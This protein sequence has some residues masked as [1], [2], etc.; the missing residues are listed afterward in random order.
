[1]YC[2]DSG[3]I[4]TR[5]SAFKL[6]KTVTQDTY[7]VSILCLCL[8]WWLLIDGTRHTVCLCFMHIRIQSIVKPTL[9]Y[10]TK[11]QRYQLDLADAHKLTAPSSR[12]CKSAI[13]SSRNST[14]DS[15]SII[16]PEGMELAPCVCVHIHGPCA[17]V[18][19]FYNWRSQSWIDHN[20]YLIDSRARECLELFRIQNNKPGLSR[21]R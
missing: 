20:S 7:N 15:S 13:C 8:S 5:T 16:L 3:V 2:P 18:F 4:R 11:V 12:D 14:V 9:H 6:Y 1:M 10:G 19:G 17:N 21:I